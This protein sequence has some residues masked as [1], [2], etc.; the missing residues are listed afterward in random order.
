MSLDQKTR[1]LTAVGI[2]VALNCT[3]C[4]D[5]HLKQARSLEIDDKDI[6]EVIRMVRD[7]KIN[8]SGKL[9]QHAAH[10]LGQNILSCTGPMQGEDRRTCC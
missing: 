8:T 1:E 7:M 6:A 9:F 5:Y 4:L 10:Q 2:S 3:H